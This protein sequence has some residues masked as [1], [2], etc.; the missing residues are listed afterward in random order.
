MVGR[1]VDHRRRAELLDAAVDHAAEHGFA[2]LSWRTL[3]SALGVSS[4]TLVHHFGTKEELLAAVLARLRDR[5]TLAVGDAPDLAAAARAVW[6]QSSDP[7]RRPTFR[8]FFAVLGQ[9]LQAP[10]AY[11]GFLD[12]VGVEWTGALCRAQG[13]GTDPAEAARRAT[14]VVA[15]LRGLL[16]DLLAGG[17]EAR[18]HGAAEAYLAAL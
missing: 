9:A 4:T 11:A 10:E 8:L 13:P 6:A 14:L 17:D 3:A 2:D 1:P 7:A 18:V 16:L 15:T 12:V 5:M